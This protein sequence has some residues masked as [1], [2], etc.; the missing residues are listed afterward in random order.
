MIKEILASTL[1][2][3]CI[4]AQRPQPHKAIGSSTVLSGQYTLQDT[5]DF[6][7]VLDVWTE[8]TQPLAL[9]YQ[10]IIGTTGQRINEIT[11][12]GNLG[13]DRD[14]YNVSSITLKVWKTGIARLYI[15]DKTD[16]YIELEDIVNG[17][18]ITYIEYYGNYEAP[19]ENLVI[20]FNEEYYL[21][22][23]EA[24]IFNTLFN[25]SGNR[26]VQFYNGYYHYNNTGWYNNN[27]DYFYSGP[28]F[29]IKNGIYNACTHMGTCQYEVL[30]SENSVYSVLD[31]YKDGTYTNVSNININGLLPKYVRDCMNSE[32]TFN[33]I[34]DTEPST[35]YEMILSTMD[36]PIYYLHGLLGFELFG[37]NLFVAFSSLLT[38]VLII[39]VIKK[40]I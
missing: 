37:I 14:M 10:F 17:H 20:N 23:F 35:W 21:N 12:F 8:Y 28:L 24:I 31:V 13:G 4:N 5:Y 26:Y 7:N 3:T 27:Y 15:E 19:L 1:L 2:C 33:F 34:N 39:T 29:I 22:G 30:N 25:K 11:M 9:D 6:T 38:L 16:N 32:G 36:A 18:E 40:V